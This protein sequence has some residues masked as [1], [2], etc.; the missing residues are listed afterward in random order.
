MR[1]AAELRGTLC[2][3]SAATRLL[4]RREFISY[5]NAPVLTLVITTRFTG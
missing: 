3:S 5:R 4:R 2:D 1:E